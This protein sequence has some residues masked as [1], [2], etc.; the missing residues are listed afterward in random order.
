[1]SG[2]AELAAKEFKTENVRIA[3]PGNF[4]GP[5]EMYRSPEF[6]TVTG[7]LLNGMSAVRSRQEGEKRQGAKRGK[8]DP[9]SFLRNFLQWLKEFF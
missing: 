9:E 2:I 7:L 4:G 3:R 6:A 1:M 5:A 8:A